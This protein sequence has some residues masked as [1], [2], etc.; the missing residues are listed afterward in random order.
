MNSHYS[1]CMTSQSLLMVSVSM[2]D[3]TTT[4]LLLTRNVDLWFKGEFEGQDV[5]DEAY[6][7][8]NPEIVNML[9]SFCESSM[10]SRIKC[11]IRKVKYLFSNP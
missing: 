1:C 8:N 7:V 11:R 4:R 2:N 3:P 5:L 6:R 10:G 9:Y